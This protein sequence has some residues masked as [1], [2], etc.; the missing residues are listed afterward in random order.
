[1]RMLLQEF[2]VGEDKIEIGIGKEV[3][4]DIRRDIN[5]N[6]NRCNKF[7]GVLLLLVYRRLLRML[8]REV[9]RLGGGRR[10]IRIRKLIL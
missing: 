10:R 1:M 4:E 2:T 8:D 9:L 7:K 6:N 3:M 5:R